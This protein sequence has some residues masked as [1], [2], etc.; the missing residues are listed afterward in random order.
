MANTIAFRIHVRIIHA[1]TN[2]KNRLVFFRCQIDVHN[3]LS[4]LFMCPLFKAKC[5]HSKEKRSNL[6]RIFDITKTMILVV[7]TW[8]M[9]RGAAAHTRFLV[10][11]FRLAVS[12]SL[13]AHRHATNKIWTH[14]I[15]KALPYSTGLT[16]ISE[17]SLKNQI[18]NLSILRVTS[19]EWAYVWVMFIISEHAK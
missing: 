2:F 4:D 16:L 19:T 11:T 3:S 5:F 15:N 9:S 8:R 7:R 10:K 13:E 14:D 18:I 1:K 17:Q 12:T 6:R